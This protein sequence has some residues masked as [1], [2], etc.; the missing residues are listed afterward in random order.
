MSLDP[1]QHLG[2]YDVVSSLGAGGMG[3]VYR[4]RD[5]RLGRDVA[6]KLLPEALSADPDRIARLEREAR[7][8]A[9]LNHPGIAQIY[10]LERV[11]LPDGT[12]VHFL[13]MELVDGIDLA[14]RLGRGPVPV[15][16]SLD[17][18]LQIAAALEQA[19]EKGIVHR[20]LKPANVKVTGEGT[21]KVLDFGLAKEYSTDAISGSAPDLSQ[22]PTLAR[23]G[24]AAG[25]IL[26]TAGYMSP[27]QARGKAVDKRADIWAFGVLLWELLTGRALFTGE[28]VSDVL[29]GVLT[30]EPEWSALPD[31]ARPVQG[32]L[33]RC[34]ER[35]PRKRFRDIGDVRV[36]L[37]RARAGEDRG[38]LDAVQRPRWRAPLGLALG[39]LAAAAVG[40]LLARLVAPA[41]PA[42]R[43]LRLSISLSST[44]QI[45]VADNAVLTFSPD[46]G[47][48]AASVLDGGKPCVLSRRLD[49]AAAECVAG[50]EGGSAPFFSPDG[51]WLGFIAGGKLRKVAADGGRPVA[52]ANEQGAA[53]AAW[54]RDGRIVFS[55]VY[56]DGLFRVSA[57]GGEPQRLTTPDRKRGELGHW[58]PQILPGGKAAVFTAFCSPLD[59][60][61]IGVVSLETG[62]VKDVLEGG[63]FGRYVPTG[64]LLF[65]RGGRLFAAPFDAKSASLTGPAKSVLDDVFVSPTEALSILD[66]SVDGTLAWVPASVADAPREIV[67]VDRDGRSRP[68]T[69]EARRF[70]GAAVSPDGRLLATAIMGDSLDL[71]TFS[72]ARQTLSRVTTGPR[73]E[74]DPVWSPDGATLFYVVDRPP[75]EIWRIPVGST[76]EG[77]PLWKADLDTVL[78]GLSP[79]G[80]LVVYTVTEPET[81]RNLWVRP[82]DGAEPGKAFRATRYEENFGTFSPDGRWLAYSSDETGRSEIYV[83]AFPG[84]GPRFQVSPD[85]G[86]EP[87]WTRGSGEIFYRHGDEMRVVRA[88]TGPRFEFE[89]PLTL[90][91]LSFYGT[92]S[93]ARSY[94]VSSDGQRVFAVHV[95]DL[96]APRRIEIVT[97]W[98]D[99]LRR[100]GAR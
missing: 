30:R 25:L 23:A 60:S 76:A 70:R 83:E 35:D 86:T 34:L 11:T 46:G 45:S 91:T 93:D 55:P 39:L 87:R 27:E 64:H 42:S 36:E 78:G 50:T 2:P 94:D 97:H 96:A 47:R 1:G 92:G 62:E 51:S 16:E 12:A 75:F 10:G 68:M 26:G 59:S 22:S 53:G 5:P 15:D 95:P 3:E 31:A 44:Q 9:A 74:F 98:L 73:T 33:A 19:H 54:G 99:T 77:E 37:E 18:A 49:D 6:L 84:P 82:T 66:V 28:T 63:F 61:R 72:P 38:P 56:S 4:A 89:P 20:D 21:V 57:E 14:E 90:F 13:A 69:A 71:W 29:A 48:I 81:G 67:V 79:D 65:V 85:G 58:W 41:A 88:R 43:S 80:R 32:V 17:I 7:V 40:G 24:T 52:L 100:E 8:L